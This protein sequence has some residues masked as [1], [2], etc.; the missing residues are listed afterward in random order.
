M[1]INKFKKIYF[2]VETVTMNASAINL[3]VVSTTVRI[4]KFKIQLTL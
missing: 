2:D 4:V 1:L 3:F